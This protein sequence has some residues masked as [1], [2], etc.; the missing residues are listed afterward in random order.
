[1]KPIRAY[2][3][4]GAND[5]DRER[6]GKELETMTDYRAFCIINKGKEPPAPDA[7]SI[8]KTYRRYI[9]ARRWLEENGPAID[10]ARIKVRET[11]AALEALEV[12]A[13]EIERA[14]G[15]SAAG[16][17][18]LEKFDA[19][20]KSLQRK[21][22]EAEKYERKGEH[23]GREVEKAADAAADAGSSESRQEAGEPQTN[24]SESADRKQIPNLF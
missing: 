16:K 8:G 12:K 2:Y 15:L 19:L 18:L 1:M 23:Y 11:S 5:A 3:L 10:A 4:T 6:V 7:E 9:E 22:N 20:R 17:A 24:E 14:N 13:R 21:I